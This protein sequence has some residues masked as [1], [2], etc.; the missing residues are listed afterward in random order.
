MPPQI[1]KPPTQSRTAGALHNFAKIVVETFFAHIFVMKRRQH[2]RA[3]TA[4]S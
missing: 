4:C 1:E 2:Q 3:R